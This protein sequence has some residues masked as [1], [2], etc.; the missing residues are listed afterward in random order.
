MGYKVKNEEDIDDEYYSI[1]SKEIKMETDSKKYSKIKE[2]AIEL[3]VSRDW[4]PT[5]DKVKVCMLDAKK[6]LRSI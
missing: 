1:L 6:Y 5:K 4:K 2:I 3:M